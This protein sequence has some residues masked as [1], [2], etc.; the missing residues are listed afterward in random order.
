MSPKILL[1]SPQGQNCFINIQTIFLF[2]TLTLSQL[3]SGDLKDYMMFDGL[4]LTAGAIV[5]GY[6]YSSVLKSSF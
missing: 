6:S 3:H 2:L 1:V 5:L 4:I